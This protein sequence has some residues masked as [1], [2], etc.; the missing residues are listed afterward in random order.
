[1]AHMQLQQ[2]Q[3]SGS[4]GALCLRNHFLIAMPNTDMAAD[5]SDSYFARSVVYLCDHSSE[6]SSGIVINRPA[7]LTFEQLFNKIHLPLGR[8][9]IAESPIFDGGPVDTGKG[10]VLH[11]DIREKDGSGAYDSSITITEMQVQLTSSKDIIDDL[12]RGAGPQNLLM[13]LGYAAWHGG[14]LEEE[15]AANLWL[16]VEADRDI[17]FHVPPSQRYQRALNLLGLHEPWALAPQAGH[18]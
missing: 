11:E 13:V 5:D 6:G 18:A 17:L 7:D 1:M 3:P 12:A 16:T 14:Q 15:L 4:F 10:F 9:D 2:T 8:A